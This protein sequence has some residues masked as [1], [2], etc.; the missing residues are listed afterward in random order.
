MSRPSNRSAP[1]EAANP[2]P[3]APLESTTGRRIIFYSP[4]YDPV[5]GVV[6]IFDYINHALAAGMQVEFA[7]PKP[8]PHEGP[9]QDIPHIAHAL[10]NIKI[11]RGLDVS[12]GRDDLAFFSWPTHYRDI[13]ECLPAGYRHDQ[14]I[15]IVQNVRHANPHWINGYATRLLG[16]PMSRIMITDQ[17][18]DV[19]QP[20]VNPN[21]I[22][23]TIIEGHAADYFSKARFGQ[24]NNPIRVGYT[25]WKSDVGRDVERLLADDDRFVF[26]SIQTTAGWS[27]I[28]SLYHW[29]DIFLG[30]P[31]P[32]EGFYLVGLE[33]MAAGAILV[34][35]DAGGNRAYAQWG[36][37]CLQVRHDSA[38]DYVEK[39]DDLATSHPEIVNGLRLSGYQTPAEF[40]LDREAAEF[41]QMAAKICDPNHRQ[42]ARVNPEHDLTAAQTTPSSQRVAPSA[43]AALPAGL[44]RT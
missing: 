28:R 43:A 20:W 31:G 15:H 36:K 40:T 3:Q 8:F 13:A 33:A 41:H 27:D 17:V 42:P 5:G 6:K 29:S 35:S 18:E 12:V 9:I 34:M 2:E 30:C 22:T 10:N 1:A 25:T 21:S 16:R 23:E 39:I 26:E 14:L 24:F 37:N 38:S 19:C 44:S 7:C 4:T 32:E 11:H